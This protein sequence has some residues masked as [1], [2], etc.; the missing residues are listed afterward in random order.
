[1]IQLFTELCTM[2]FDM[3]IRYCFVVLILGY[4][5]K[6]TESEARGIAMLKGEEVIRTNHSIPGIE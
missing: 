5:G 1:M 2:V 6:R 3:I 4:F